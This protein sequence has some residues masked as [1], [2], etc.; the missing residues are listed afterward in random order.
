MFVKD[1]QP[2]LNRDIVTIIERVR[3]VRRR[4]ERHQDPQNVMQVQRVQSCGDAVRGFELRQAHSLEIGHGR[5]EKRILEAITLPDRTD[6]VD[7]PGARQI[8]RLERQ[9]RIKKTGETRGEVVFG[10]TSLPEN[11]ADAATLLVLCRGHWSIENRSHWVRDVTFDEDR[12]SVRTGSIPQVMAALRNTSIGL[13]RIAGHTN[14][15]AACRTH[16]YNAKNLLP[17]IQKPPTFK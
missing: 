15:A 3:E 7:W 8:F 4:V 13:L 14:I 16:A 6:G 10:I 5:I 1:N 9:T 12:S 17:L 11:R 2:T